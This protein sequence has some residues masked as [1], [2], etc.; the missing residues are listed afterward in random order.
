MKRKK[1]KKQK[2]SKKRN[3]RSYK[4]KLKRRTQTNKKQVTYSSSTRDNISDVI[5][6]TY[7]PNSMFSKEIKDVLYVTSYKKLPHNILNQIEK[8][9]E[10]TPIRKGMCHV[11]SSLVTMNIRG[12]ETCRGWYSENIFDL[13][14]RLKE[15]LPN[16]DKILQ[17][18]NNILFVIEKEKSLNNEW[19][20][21]KF[22]PWSNKNVNLNTKTGEFY[23]P[24]SWNVYNGIHFD[25]SNEFQLKFITK[26]IWTYYK[27]KKQD[28]YENFVFGSKLSENKFKSKLKK[29]TTEFSG[30]GID[31]GESHFVMN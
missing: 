13:N 29:Y 20:L 4:K 19:I 2:M 12:V 21:V 24:H 5:Y 10:E 28:T 25:L 9:I 15:Y 31:L 26:S 1:M 8:H 3:T 14:K 27:L 17:S 23:L 30:S 18:I 6:Q 11:N 22:S 7:E 16:D